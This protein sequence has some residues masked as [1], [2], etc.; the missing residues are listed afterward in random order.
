MKDNRQTHLWNQDLVL[1]LGL[2]FA[3]VVVLQG[4]LFPAAAVLD[5]S[6]V[7][8]LLAW[9]IVEWWPVLL[10]ISGIVLWV[11]AG[12]TNKKKISRPPAPAGGSK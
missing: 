2:A 12:R 9:K 11:R 8:T 10:I 6:F 7:H 3:G 5:V 4:K 1:A